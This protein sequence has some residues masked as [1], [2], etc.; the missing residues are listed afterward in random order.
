MPIR[1][2]NRSR[3]PAD[4]PQISAAIRDRAGNR[5][6]RCGVENGAL[7]FR[8]RHGRIAAWRY[9]KDPHPANSRCPDDGSEI[10]GTCW[11]DFER[12]TQDPVEVVLTVAHLDHQPEN[13]APDNLRAWCQRCHNAYDAPMRR[14]GIA[15]RARAARA[16]ADLFQGAVR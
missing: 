4:W 2:E 3:Y 12:S 16:V 7:I 15:A 10:P 9:A 11:D 8:G 5:C 13:C 1:P 14:A 6:E